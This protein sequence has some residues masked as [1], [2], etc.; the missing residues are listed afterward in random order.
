[1]T[2]ARIAALA[3]SIWAAAQAASAQDFARETAAYR[4]LRAICEQDGGRLWRASLCGPLIVAD[5]ETRRVW[6]SQ[7]DAGGVLR[8]AGEGW[9]GE[10]PPGVPI[11]NASVDWGGQRW[12]MLAAP[13]PEDATERRVLVAHEAW[14]RIQRTIGLPALSSDC[15]HLETERGRY[16]LRLEMRALAVALRSGG[17]ARRQA[18]QHALGFRMAR[19]AE[20]PAAAAG[21]ASLDRNEGLAAYT[22]V[23]LGAGD[24]A[25]IF[26]ARTLDRYD[27]HDAYARAYAYATGPAQ[28]LLL[29][30][31]DSDW[32]LRLGAYAP[33]DMLAMAVNARRMTGQE[34]REAAARYG[35]PAIA[36]EERA[37]AEEQRA[38][39][40]EFRRLFSEG[41][42]LVLPLSDSQMEFDPNRVTPVDGL[43][44]VYAVLVI[45]DA[46][47]ELRA[48]RGALISP[49]FTQVVVP[50]PDAS[51][52]AGPGWTLGLAPA[53]RPTPGDATGRRTV[54]IIPDPL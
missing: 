40:A 17:A 54:E 53:Y 42:R 24:E 47:G 19:F 13:L 26:A 36:V 23:R 16:L 5:P 37:R 45:R 10:L 11:A 12:T 4:D 38:Q 1:M 34:L 25:E 28:G 33:A 39:L 6:A 20:F 29:D 8:P 3:A 14:H 35:G 30:R 22:G 52:L 50:A 44:S 32:R 41:P 9:T 43:G 15:S 51:G 46:W 7:A 49:D 21:E 2:I 31:M 48:A 18:A 27:T